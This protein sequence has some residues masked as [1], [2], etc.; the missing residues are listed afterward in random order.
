MLEQVTSNEETGATCGATVLKYERIVFT[1][2]LTTVANPATYPTIKLNEA[3][4]LTTGLNVVVGTPTNA[5][6]PD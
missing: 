6:E 1:P 5:H 4:I 2:V 3:G